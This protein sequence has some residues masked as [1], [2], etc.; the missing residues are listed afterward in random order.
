[1]KTRSSAAVGAVLGLCLALEAPAWCQMR[2]D[3]LYGR[4][5]RVDLYQVG[6]PTLKRLADSTAAL[7][8]AGAVR[9]EGDT[10]QLAL[11]EYGSSYN[12]CK[13]ERFY[14]QPVGA[15]CSGALVAP[16]LILT[17]GHCV[18]TDADCRDARVV[19]GFAMTRE[20]R[21]PTAVPASDVY[22]CS[23]IKSVRHEQGGVD[24]SLIELDRPVEG[25]QPLKV[26]GTG[27]VEKGEPLV[28]RGCPSGL[29]LKVAA[30][31]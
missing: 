16:N 7:F 25:R 23:K 8:Q 28:L 26:N 22:K 17:A 24:F 31:G 29:P 19:F 18:L 12:L 10:A 13:G 15:R 3:A 6:D 21:Y 1:M 9:I 20:G 27:R 30:G 11:Y 4:D 5:D 14:S 2:S